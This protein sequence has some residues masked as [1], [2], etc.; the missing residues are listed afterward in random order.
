MPG[1]ARLH[2]PLYPDSCGAIVPPVPE[3]SH[4]RS[5]GI[6]KVALRPSEVFISECNTG[7][8]NGIALREERLQGIAS[9]A[10]P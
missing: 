4:P 5:C 1:R 3:R 6:L 10:T 7:N 2:R 9:K 8:G